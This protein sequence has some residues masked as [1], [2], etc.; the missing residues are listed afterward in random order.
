MNHAILRRNHKKLLILALL[1]LLLPIDA[2][3]LLLCA[4][5]GGEFFVFPSKSLTEYVLHIEWRA[6]LDGTMRTESQDIILSSASR[7]WDAGK[8]YTYTFN[9]SDT[10]HILFD[11]PAVQE[12]DDAAGGIIIVD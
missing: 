5:F 2:V 9:I 1:V 10:D 4:L 11:T 8:K 7:T 3:L 6:G 12:W